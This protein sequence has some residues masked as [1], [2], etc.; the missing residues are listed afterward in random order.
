MKTY[1]TEDNLIADKLA[2]LSDLPGDYAPNLESK[3]EVL[4]TSLI[5]TRKNK[6]KFI[7]TLR[8]AA[9]LII[10]G[11]LAVFFIGK[12][13]S[14]RS[15][16]A[17]TQTVSLPN[18]EVKRFQKSVSPDIIQP[19]L[20]SKSQ[21]PKKRFLKTRVKVSPQI[22]SDY[23]FTQTIEQTGNT[24]VIESAIVQHLPI[25]EPPHKKEKSRY[26]QVDFEDP[27]I[28][29]TVPIQTTIS[30]NFQIK[31]FKQ[32]PPDQIGMQDQ[33]ESK[34]LRIKL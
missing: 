18:T 3:W 26:T 29:K 19:E 31:F 4:E 1:K 11:I 5:E 32:N 20:K 28:L 33:T 13:T 27:A 22:K 24:P 16:S 12:H 17:L 23:L 8:V 21:F 34:S 15:T 25:Q 10:T 9:S 2:S 14:T 30:S 7:F 6:R